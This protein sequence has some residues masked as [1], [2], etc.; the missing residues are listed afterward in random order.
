MSKQLHKVRI[1]GEPGSI[2]KHIFVDDYEIPNVVSAT[3]CYAVNTVPRVFLEMAV[4]DVETD[5]Q[6]ATVTEYKNPPDYKKV[7]VDGK[8]Y[9]AYEDK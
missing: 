4:L 5:E 1:V 3:V 6:K 9:N 7:Y 2:F 8:T